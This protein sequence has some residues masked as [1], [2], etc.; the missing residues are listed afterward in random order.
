MSVLNVLYKNVCPQS[1]LSSKSPVLNVACP[2]CLVL[3]VAVLNVFCP[4]CPIGFLCALRAQGW[5]NVPF[6]NMYQLYIYAGIGCIMPTLG[7]WIKV[8]NK[9]YKIHCGQTLRLWGQTLRTDIEDRHF[10]QYIIY[11]V[12]FIPENTNAQI[13]NYNCVMLFS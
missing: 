3:N 12:S 1:R 4:Q 7:G 10:P 8:D 2:Q 5:E 11:S 9:Y 6:W 13:Q